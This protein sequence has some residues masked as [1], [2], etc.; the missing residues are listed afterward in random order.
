MEREADSDG[1]EDGVRFERARSPGERRPRP[2]VVPEIALGIA[3][4]FADV[5]RPELED[6]WI[7]E[8]AGESDV[9]E[10]E[11]TGPPRSRGPWFH[12]RRLLRKYST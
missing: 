8:E 5:V 12:G 4:G 6:H 7:G 10:S 11:E 3:S 1:V 2:P 9:P